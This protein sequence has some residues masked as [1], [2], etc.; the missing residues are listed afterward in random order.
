MPLSKNGDGLNL[1]RNPDV[2]NDDDGPNL[3]RYPDGQNYARND[4]TYNIISYY[5]WSMSTNLITTYYTIPFKA[6]HDTLYLRYTTVYLDTYF[7]EYSM[8]G[9]T[10]YFLSFTEV[11]LQILDRYIDVYITKIP[12]GSG[13]V[14]EKSTVT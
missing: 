7:F 8:G 4:D 11:S 1:Q 2:G 10:K 9:C 5:I 12:T 6:E 14:H 3:Q 13:T